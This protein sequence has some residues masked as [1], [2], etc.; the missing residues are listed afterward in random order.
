MDDWFI[1]ERDEN[2][3][4]FRNKEEQNDV[5]LYTTDARPNRNG[6]LDQ[7]SYANFSGF[8]EQHPDRFTLLG[9]LG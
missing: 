7:V 8:A 5:D 1:R 3:L 6:G 2:E 4:L 9:A